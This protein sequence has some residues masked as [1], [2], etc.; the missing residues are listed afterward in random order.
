FCTDA[1][2]FEYLFAALPISSLFPFL[3]FMVRDFHI[4]DREENIS[5]YAG[6]VGS[7]FMLGRA[8]TSIPWGMIADRYGRKPVIVIGAIT[9]V[10]FNALFGLS[11]NFW[12]AIVM[13]FLLGS[14]CGIIG[15]MR[16]YASEICRKEYHA[17]GLSAIS[18]SWGIGLVIGP[19]IGGYLAQVYLVFSPWYDS[20]SKFCSSENLRTT[21]LREVSISFI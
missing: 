11:T 18:T 13:R 1:F 16:A 9:V 6:Y 12:M 21:L 2:S 3:Y 19:A 4:A 15:T 5:Y 7:S 17:L 8:L 14:L 10:I 20:V